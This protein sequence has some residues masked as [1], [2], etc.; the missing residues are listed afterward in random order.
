[1]GRLNHIYG[2]RNGESLLNPKF[3]NVLFKSRPMIK[4]E[5]YFQ[6]EKKTLLI[7]ISTIFK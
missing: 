3:R 1:M 5:L 6:V 7:S 4:E 2:V